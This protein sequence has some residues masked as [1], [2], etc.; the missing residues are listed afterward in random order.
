MLMN[1]SKHIESYNDD[2]DE[3]KDTKIS[4]ISY[5]EAL[6]CLNIIKWLKIN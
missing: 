2:E 4:I 1:I 6:T 3:A 5:R